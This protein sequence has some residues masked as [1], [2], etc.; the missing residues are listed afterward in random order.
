M[1]HSHESIALQVRGKQKC[2]CV[3]VDKFGIEQPQPP[4][5]KERRF[6][7]LHRSSRSSE[8]VFGF[9]HPGQAPERL[10]RYERERGWGFPS[11]VWSTP[12]FQTACVRSAFFPFL[13]AWRL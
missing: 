5:P 3:P 6:R 4:P 7:N 10:D 8:R 2:P 12:R 9:G 13:L 1:P 11:S